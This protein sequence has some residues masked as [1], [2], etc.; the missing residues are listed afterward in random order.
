MKFQ[1]TVIEIINRTQLVR[2]IRTTKPENFTFKAGQF[3]KILSNSGTKYL[4]ISCAPSRNFL[5]FTKRITESDFSQRF[6]DLKQQDLIVFEGPFGNFVLDDD[7]KIAFVAGG[8]GITP[9]YSM[10]D[11][12]LLKG[13]MENRGDFVLFYGNRTSDDIAFYNELENMSLS[14]N[15]KIFFF[16]D[17]LDTLNDDNFRPGFLSYDKMKACL[18]DITE[19]K[20]YISGPPKMVETITEQFK[21]HGIQNIKTEKIQGYSGA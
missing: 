6:N 8:I 17:N 10:L 18:P 20:I 2:S 21:A 3:V 5:E 9:I 16:L 14:M 12:L 19:R 13:N 15:L 1:C 7:R 11:E 4:S